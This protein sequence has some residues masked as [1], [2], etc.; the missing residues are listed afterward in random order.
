MTIEEI[1]EILEAEVITGSDNLK[2]EVKIGC[3]AD[4]MSDVLAFAKPGAIL[5]TGLTN[6][7]V[8]RTVEIADVKAICFV[9]GKKPDENTIKLAKDKN[10]ILLM[11]HLPMF[12][13]CGRLYKKGLVGL[14][15]LDI[16]KRN[17]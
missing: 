15:Y 16:N 6:P 11:T 9:R 5:L 3:A 17:G 8:V 1:K 2:M 14:G 13:S 10:L 12:E 7:Q 4:L